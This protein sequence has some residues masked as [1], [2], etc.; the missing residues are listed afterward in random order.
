LI[1][2]ATRFALAASGTAPGQPGIFIRHP[3]DEAARREMSMMILMLER[4]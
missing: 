1:R 4:Q 2:I 3:F